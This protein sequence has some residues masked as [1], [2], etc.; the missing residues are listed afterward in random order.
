MCG[1]PFSQRSARARSVL[2]APIPSPAA[3]RSQPVYWTDIVARRDSADSHAADAFGAP[4]G[5]H[6]ARFAIRLPGAARAVRLAARERAAAAV[7]GHGRSA[8]HAAPR[9]RSRPRGRRRLPAP[10]TAMRTISCAC[11]SRSGS[12]RLRSIAVDAADADPAAG[13]APGCRRTT[14]S[15]CDSALAGSVA[16]ARELARDARSAPA[17]RLRRRRSRG[18]TRSCA[19]RPPRRRAGLPAPAFDTRAL[20][21]KNRR[22]P[23]LAGDHGDRHAHP[24][25][26]CSSRPR[27]PCCS[28]RAGRW[29]RSRSGRR[30]S[31]SSSCSPRS[32]RRRSRPPA[33]RSSARSTSAAR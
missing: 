26:P 5:V 27:S 3:Y 20:Q 32:T 33:S 29:P 18:H 10:S 6:D 22:L 1:Y 31:P 17:A 21:G 19:S 25:R 9:R 24:T 7:R 14:R 2:A 12:R 16:E 28:P 13:G 23:P 8:G 11:T 30:T 15:P 4:H